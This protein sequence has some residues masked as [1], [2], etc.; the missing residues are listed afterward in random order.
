MKELYYGSDIA[1]VSEVFKTDVHNGISENEAKKRQENYGKN[2]IEAQE[3]NKWYL[4]LLD[5]FR[6][7]MVLVLLGA[8]L[9]SGLLGEYTDAITIIAIVVLNAV[10]GFY[11]EFKAEKSLEELKKITAPKTKVIRYGEMKE[12][13]AEDL[14]PGDLVYLESGDRVP[15]DLRLVEVSGLE[16]NEASLTGESDAVS[17][18]TDRI[19]G[20]INSLGD[21]LNLALMGTVVVNGRGKGIVLQTGMNAEM[22]KIAD[23]MQQED[24]KVETPLQKRLASLGKVLVLA[25]LVVCAL[26]VLMG[27]WRGESTY[28]MFM[29]GV[30]LAVAAIPEGLP[31]IVTIA[32]AIGVQRMMDRNALVKKLPAVETLGC[33]TVICSDKTG[34]L[35]KNKMK[36]AECFTF[37]PNNKELYQ[38]ALEIG[39]VC[40]NTRVANGKKNSNYLIGDPTEKALMEAGIKEGLNKGKILEDEFFVKENSFDSEHKMMSVL[41]HNATKNEYKLYVKGAPETM[42]EKCD[43]ILTVNGRVK[44]DGNKKEEL[45][46]N[47]EV[48]AS[49]A[50][51]NIAVAY[52]YILEDEIEKPREKQEE[53]LVFVAIFGLF[54]PPREEAASAVSSCKK[55]G[56]RPIMITGDHKNTA[57]TIARKINIMPSGGE[58]IE[59]KDI[60]NLPERDLKEKLKKAY[61]FARVSPHHKLRIV[62]AFQEL[63]HIVAMTG[64][65]INDAPAVK[66]SDIGIS[67]GKTGTDVTKNAA[68]LILSDDNFATIKA[69]IEEGRGIFDNIKKFIK[70]L[71]ACNIGEILVMFWSMLLALPLPLKP[72]QILWVNLVTD[73]FPAIALGLDSKDK[74]IM[75]RP[76]RDPSEGIFTKNFSSAIIRRGFLISLVTLFAFYRSLQ[77]NPDIHFARTMALSTLVVCQLFFVFECQSTKKHISLDKIIK[78]PA[79]P[80]SII[81]S[82]LMLLLVIYQPFFANI[83][84]TYPLNS[85]EWIIVIFLSILPGIGE[86]ILFKTKNILTELL[87]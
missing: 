32:L 15:A 7:F 58:V 24:I 81:I 38:K 80:I 82:F 18:I 54:D 49:K 23:L 30:S 31:A 60:E 87:N 1:E 4:I 53:K 5:Q 69:A 65:G 43:E 14:V 22:G 57:L 64:D 21:Y 84:D 56:I 50:Y 48:L 59:G 6:D 34:T 11:Q 29:A 55:A 26:V 2:E 12:I 28:N 83:F 8:T 41:Y 3:D 86:W 27:I 47:N 74:D 75:D 61:V 42:I 39:V 13:A 79:V 63:G 44:L 62:R 70:F 40:N 9:L 76:P 35:T 25:C 78:N 36:L 66:A 51:R 85:K 37:E 10:L 19:F 73:G 33:A 45:L 77:I 52:K 46:K 67:M 16:C 71:L 20:K 68:D 17:K 72:I